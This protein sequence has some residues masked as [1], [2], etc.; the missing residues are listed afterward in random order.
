MPSFPSSP[1]TPW[2]NTEKKEILL[3]SLILPYCVVICNLL[4]NL[5]LTLV[6]LV[7]QVL[8]ELAVN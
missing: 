8:L 3:S 7:V 4:K 2:K 5:H 1:S 6:I